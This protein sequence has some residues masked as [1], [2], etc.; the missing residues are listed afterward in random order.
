MQRCAGGLLADLPRVFR[1]AWRAVLGDFCGRS[2][3]WAGFC[4]SR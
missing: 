2:G 1:E 3:A 4:G